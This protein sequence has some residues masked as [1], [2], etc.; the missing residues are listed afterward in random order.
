MWRVRIYENGKRI[1]TV[2]YPRNYALED[3]V[4]TASEDAPDWTYKI[5]DPQNECK[6]VIQNGKVVAS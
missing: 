4:K 6:F 3:M 2:K 5:V 1:K